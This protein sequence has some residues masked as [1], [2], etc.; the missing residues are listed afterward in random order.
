M[1]N[2]MITQT[3]LRQTAVQFVG[4]RNSHKDTVYLAPGAIEGAG[5]FLVSRSLTL[6]TLSTAPLWT[7][8][9]I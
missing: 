6:L 5:W 7:R 8:G 4:K 9:V 1:K 2:V 3:N